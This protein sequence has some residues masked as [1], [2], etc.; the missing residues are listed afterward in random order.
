[1][2]TYEITL[3]ELSTKN[4][5]NIQVEVDEA[6]ESENIVIHSK[7]KGQEIT[8][9]SDTY[10]TAYQQFR[11]KLLALSYGIKCNGSRLNAI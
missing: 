3:V 8:L 9:I 4:K 10:L 5:I 6:E 11:D 2:E 1:M 7:I